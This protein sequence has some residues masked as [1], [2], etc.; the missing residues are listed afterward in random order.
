MHPSLA[1][2]AKN[3]IPLHAVRARD[4]KAWLVRQKRSG[5]VI[6]S[7]FAG[8]AGALAVL[9]DTKGGIAAWVLGLG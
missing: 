2:S 3:A 9:P 8:A 5:L 4:A 1:N 7:G 6:A